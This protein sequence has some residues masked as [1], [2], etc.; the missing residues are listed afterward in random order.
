[1][2]GFS[3][4][5]NEDKDESEGEFLVSALP[6]AILDS[7]T[8][9]YSKLRARFFKTKKIHHQMSLRRLYLSLPLLP[10][11]LRTYSGRRDNP[12]KKVADSY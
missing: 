12:S 1:M 6:N 9:P 10:I 8:P 3:P 7:F 11:G 5:K 4:I 2:K